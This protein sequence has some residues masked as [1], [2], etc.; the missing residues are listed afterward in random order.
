VP[1]SAVRRRE[2]DKPFLPLRSASLASFVAAIGRLD[3]AL[4]TP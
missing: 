2:A 3:G 4:A 1:D